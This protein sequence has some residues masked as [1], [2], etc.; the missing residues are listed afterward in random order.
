MAPD[1]VVEEEGL[2]ALAEIVSCVKLVN[3]GE[4]ETRIRRPGRLVPAFER[5]E[6]CK[7]VWSVMREGI[8]VSRQQRVEGTGVWQTCRE[9]RRNLVEIV[10]SH[11]R[12]RT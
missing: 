11:G 7:R 8:I 9:G 6:R 2:G 12:L 1:E 4:V 5:V 3:M 10:P